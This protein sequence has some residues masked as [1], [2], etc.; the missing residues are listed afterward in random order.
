MKAALYVEEFLT[1]KVTQRQ[2]TKVSR[3][4]LLVSL[5]HL[6]TTDRTTMTLTTPAT[7]G[8]PHTHTIY[9]GCSSHCNLFVKKK[10]FYSKSVLT[11]KRKNLFSKFCPLF[12]RSD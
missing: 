3:L 2:H 7:T 8:S 5:T 6:I 10:I 11:S 1:R 12:K 9:R 4:D